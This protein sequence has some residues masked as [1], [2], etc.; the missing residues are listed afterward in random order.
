M[1]AKATDLN[2]NRN[3]DLDCEKEKE[4]PM[5]VICNIKQISIG[6][7]HHKYQM[8]VFRLQI[9]KMDASFEVFYDH[10]EATCEM[11]RTTLYDLTG[12]PYSVNPKDFYQC[13]RQ[14]PNLME[15][16]QGPILS[17][18]REMIYFNGMKM[19]VHMI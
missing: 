15:S 14:N 11:V 16:P 10:Q 18:P 8:E 17:N 1:V 5:L 19:K 12:H 13:V 6:M 2:E 4:K 9:P 7:L 3:Y